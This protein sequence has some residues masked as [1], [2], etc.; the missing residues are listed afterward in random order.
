ME[1][2]AVHKIQTCPFLRLSFS[3]P[4][5]F[6]VVKTFSSKFSWKKAAIK[7]IKILKT[8]DWETFASVKP[9]RGDEL[10]RP[11]CVPAARAWYNTTAIICHFKWIITMW[12]LIILHNAALKA[13]KGKQVVGLFLT[14]YFQVFPK[15]KEAEQQK[16]D[17]FHN[18]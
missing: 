1:Q 18:A 11:C 17:I 14:D 12:S 16:E 15:R 8:Q 6:V 13:M 10:Q 2:V 3:E 9:H 4:Q 5:S 7:E